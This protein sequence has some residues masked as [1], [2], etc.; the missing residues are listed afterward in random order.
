MFLPEPRRVSIVSG[1]FVLG[2]HR[3]HLELFRRAK[4]L[5][6]SL[7]VIVN[8]DLQTER[9]YGFVPV[10]AQERMEIIRNIRCV[11]YV[12]ISRDEDRS[13]A[14]T[15]EYVWEWYDGAAQYS[16]INGGD[17]TESNNET[18]EEITCR[19]LGIDIIYLGDEKIGSSSDVL[20]KIG[21]YYVDQHEQILKSSRDWASGVK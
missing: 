14:K 5:G 15:I 6:D 1:Y 7:V 11:D 2:P 20:K 10:S 12:L 9:K 16:F 17:R 8:N 18:S 13:V 4:E 21:D 3:Q 19:K